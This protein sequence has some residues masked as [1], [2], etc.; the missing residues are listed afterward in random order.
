MAIRSHDGKLYEITSGYSL[1]DDA[2]QYELVGL[3]GPPGTGP[4]LSVLIPDATPDGPFTP[5]PAEHVIVRAGGGIVPWPVLEELVHLL[6]SSGDLVD[7]LRDLSPEATALPLTLNT[8]SH[9]DRRF[10]VNHFH[11]GDAESWCYE[12]YEVDPATTENNYIDVRVPDA[13][14]ESGP[15]VPMPAEHV[16]LTMHGRWT[17]PWPVFR[18]FLDA[19]RAAGDIVESTREKPTP[20]DRP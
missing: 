6:D 9:D 4:Y 13:L 20:V 18:R 10:E 16:T 8:W 3:T 14:P 17:L 19:I 15:F 11:Y 2:W 12:L 1:P 5:R 7:E